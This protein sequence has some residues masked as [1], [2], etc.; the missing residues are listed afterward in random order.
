MFVFSSSFSPILPAQ[1]RGPGN[2]AIYACRASFSSQAVFTLGIRNW[3]SNLTNNTVI[4]NH[5][6]WSL[7]MQQASVDF[8]HL[9]EQ[10]LL[11][12]H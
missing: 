9:L 1:E 7:R 5:F 6:I 10:T 11:K 3:V 4:L 2:E 12:R 8:K